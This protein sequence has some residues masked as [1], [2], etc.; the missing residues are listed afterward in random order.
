ML[1]EMLDQEEKTRE[2]LEKVQKHQLPSSSLISLPA[3][4]PPKVPIY[5]SLIYID[6]LTCMCFSIYIVYTYAAEQVKFPSLDRV[7]KQQNYNM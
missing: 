1:R 7:K 2:I 3:S 6:I 5:H 4:L